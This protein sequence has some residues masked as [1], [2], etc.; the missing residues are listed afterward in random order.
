MVSFERGDIAALP[1]YFSFLKSS[2]H[3][4]VIHVWINN[5]H[6]FR[7]GVH[8]CKTSISSSKEYHGDRRRS[9]IWLVPGNELQYPTNSHQQ[10]LGAESLASVIILGFYIIVIQIIVPNAHCSIMSIL[11][12]AFNFVVLYRREEAMRDIINDHVILLQDSRIECDRFQCAAR[13]PSLFSR[14]DTLPLKNWQL[15]L[16]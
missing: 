5:V 4:W 15:I 2:K 7:L 8:Y 14:G 10:R 9:I 12:K 6:E 16:R 11:L 3:I 13:P 1:V